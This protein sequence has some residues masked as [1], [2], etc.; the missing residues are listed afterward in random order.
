MTALTDPLE[1][2]EGT[3]APGGHALT[4]VLRRLRGDRPGLVGLGIMLGLFLLVGLQLVGAFPFDPVTQRPSDRLTPPSGTYWFGTDEFGR[5]LFARTVAGLSLSLRTSLV[6]VVLAATIGTL[7]GTLA[8]YAGGI[9]D[10]VVGRFADVLFAFPAILLALTVVSALG[11]G[12]LNSS[13]AIAVVYTPIFVRVARAPVLTVKSLD[14]V[15]AGRLLGFSHARLLRRHVLPN[16]TAPVVVQTTLALSWAILTESALSFLGLGVQPPSA[17][18]GLM[19]SSSRNL[20]SEAP[21]TLIF[22]AG[23]IV[24]AVFALNL[25]GDGL[26]SALDPRASTR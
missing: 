11:T 23:A 17:S 6:A 21:W 3:T 10:A 7:L 15:A 18:L 16:I 24:L 2:T 20:L 5:D 9:F 22:P 25:L 13:L 8:G 4:R 12:W 26:R 1:A 19:V 14:Y